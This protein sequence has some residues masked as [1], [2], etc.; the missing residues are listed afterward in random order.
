ML[1]QQILFKLNER[2]KYVRAPDGEER[3]KN[4]PPGPISDGNRSHIVRLAK[5][6]GL[7]TRE[8]VDDL[9]TRIGVDEHGHYSINNAIPKIMEMNDNKKTDN[10]SEEEKSEGVDVS[11]DRE[12]DAVDGGDQDN[13]QLDLLGSR[14]R[15]V[16][17]NGR[18]Y[19]GTIS[20]VHYRVSYDD[21]DTETLIS[22]AEAFE[23]LACNDKF[24]LNGPSVGG[25]DLCCS[26]LE[27]F[28]GCSLLSTL[29]KRK[30]MNVMSIDTDMDSNATIKADFSSNYVQHLLSSQ[31]FDFVHAS[32]VCSTYSLM[33][34]GKHRNHANYNRTRESHEGDAMLMKLYFFL[35]KALK[36][37]DGMTTVTI[38][39]PRAW[40]RHGNI[41]KELFEKELG[42]KR[43]TINYCQ[44]GRGDMKPTNIWTNDWKLG[45]IL[46][47]IGG[48][49][50]CS[51]P[52]EDSVRRTGNKV[53]FAA[54]PLKLCQIITSYVHSKHTQ[55][56]FENFAKNGKSIVPRDILNEE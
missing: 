42:F 24:H 33:A 37:T 25:E 28:S 49:C 51:L 20:T 38:E 6:F 34:G 1:L 17:E 30:G 3:A 54:L 32:P 5:Q 23:N 40:M 15:T 36:K 7:T 52:H 8:D 27:I 41:M 2:T 22:K 48:K 10:T 44:F 19:E 18:E 11:N 16:F 21:G 14:V 56:R 45:N 26:A 9:F 50:D 39:N 35:A 29:C 31:T 55:L 4:S 53:N 46:E 43:F 13:Q 47:T 12:W